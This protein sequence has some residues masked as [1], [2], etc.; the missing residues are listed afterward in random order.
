[1]LN[2]YCNNIKTPS[3]ENC[4]KLKLKNSVTLWC[5][6]PKLRLQHDCGCTNTNCADVEMH[7]ACLLWP[8]RADQSERKG[9]FGR[10]ALKNCEQIQKHSDKEWMEALQQWTV[11]EEYCNFWKITNIF[12]WTPKRVWPWE[13]GDQCQVNNSITA[14]PKYNSCLSTLP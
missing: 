3:T 7:L 5:Q 9:L 1:M 13:R 11:W 2:K 4:T 14:D 12:S 10:G 6:H 8:V